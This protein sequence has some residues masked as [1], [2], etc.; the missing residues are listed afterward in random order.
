FHAYNRVAAF[1]SCPHGTRPMLKRLGWILLVG[2]CSFLGG[3][4]ALFGLSRSDTIGWAQPSGSGQ[5]QKPV[6]TDLVSISDRFELVVQ[7]VSPAVVYVESRKPAET[8]N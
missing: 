2:G 7:R 8:S 3:A 1:T 4:V 6:V 5:S